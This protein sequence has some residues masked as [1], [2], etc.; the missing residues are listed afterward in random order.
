MGIITEITR[1]KGNK[2]RVSIFVDG[3][4]FCGLD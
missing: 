3:M 4:F 1:Q 2:K